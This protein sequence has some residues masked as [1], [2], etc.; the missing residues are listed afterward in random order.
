MTHGDRGL[1][2]PGE[3]DALHGDDRRIVELDELGHVAVDRE[4]SLTERQVRR[5]H[6]TAMV[7]GPESTGRLFD[8]A[9][10]EGRRPGV[11]AQDDH[12]ATSA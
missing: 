1:G 7:D 4:E 5:G 11:D 2:I 3:E 6:E 12:P 10:S 9:P 8:E